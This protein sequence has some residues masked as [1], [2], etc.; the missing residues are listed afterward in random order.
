MLY[1]IYLASTAMLIGA[2]CAVQSQ[3]VLNGNLGLS[4][5]PSGSTPIDSL[6]Y[7]GENG[8][9]T[10]GYQIGETVADFTVYDF[11]GNPLTLSEKL[12]GEKPV[13]LLCGSVTCNRF[14]DMFDPTMDSQENV[15]SRTF[16]YDNVDNF[17]WVFVYVAEAHPWEGWCPSNCYAGPQMD[18]LVLQHP[19]YH[20]RRYALR[21]WIQSNDHDFPFNMYADN[22]DNAMYDNFFRRPSGTVIVNCAGQ[23][24]MRGDWTQLF[25]PA[26]SD[27]IL[28]LLNEPFQTC[29]T[30][31][32]NQGNS[33][34][35]VNVSDLVVYPNPVQGVLSVECPSSGTLSMLDFT[36]RQVW[37]QRVNGGTRFVE[38]SGL[39]QGAYIGTFSGLDGVTATFRVLKN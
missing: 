30:D 19:D 14:R 7:H 23:V 27:A 37:Q 16:M 38:T 13:I 31:E 39:P 24:V 15:V 35:E 18:T 28:A 20:Y 5:W 21:N 33:I 2:A 6:P 32:E 25:L 34:E 1:K 29:I 12:A 9:M 36:G 3:I 22:P 26:N 17:E 8:D 11:N 4:Q 10:G